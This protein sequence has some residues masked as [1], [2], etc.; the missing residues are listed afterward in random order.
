[1]HPESVETMRSRIVERQDGDGYWNVL[2]QGDKGYPEFNYYVPN[3]T[4]TLWTLLLPTE[5]P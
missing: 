3:C 5:G 1:M 4:S 2:R